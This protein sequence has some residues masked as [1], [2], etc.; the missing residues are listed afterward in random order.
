MNRRTR[1]S[2]RRRGV[3]SPSGRG[4]WRAAAAREEETELAQPSTEQSRG[5]W[6]SRRGYRVGKR[7]ARARQRPSPLV[8]PARRGPYYVDYKKQSGGAAYGGGPAG[9]GTYTHLARRVTGGARSATRQR[10]RPPVFSLSIYALSGLYSVRPPR[11][12]RFPRYVEAAALQT[13]RAPRTANT[14]HNMHVSQ[15]LSNMD[16]MDSALS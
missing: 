16:D 3:W 5:A 10:S 13:T 8:P 11:D 1:R 6:V 2:R 4:W 14:S 9:R 12:F 7:I 15:I